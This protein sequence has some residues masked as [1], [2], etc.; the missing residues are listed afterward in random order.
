MT[1]VVRRYHVKT[2]TSQTD[3][4]L[5]NRAI[6][7]KHVVSPAL[8]APEYALVSVSAERDAVAKVLML[9]LTISMIYVEFQYLFTMHWSSYV[10]IANK[11]GTTGR[12]SRSW[13]L[14]RSD[15]PANQHRWLY[16][17]CV[18][19]KDLRRSFNVLGNPTSSMKIFTRHSFDPIVGHRART[20]ATADLHCQ[21]Q[22][23]S[24]IDLTTMYS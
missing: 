2:N 12:F 21:F 23:S 5:T 14:E 7:R 17:M 16:R 22:K 4:H 1:G 13:L 3:K 8:R 9:L 20:H 15:S 6:G 18:T 24:S 11:I 19:D 10:V